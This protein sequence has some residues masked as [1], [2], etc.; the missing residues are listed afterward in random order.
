MSDELKDLI[1]KLLEKDPK[2]RLGCENDADDIVNHPW[3]AD[4]DWEALMSRSMDSPFSP[5]MELIRKKQADSVVHYD[6]ET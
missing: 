6:L 1:K 5:D 3:F 2:Q 4:M